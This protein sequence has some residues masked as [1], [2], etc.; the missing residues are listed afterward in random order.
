MQLAE[1]N[2]DGSFSTQAARRDV[3]AQAGKQL[4]GAGFRNLGAEGLKPKHVQKLLEVWKSDGLGVATIKNRVAHL[5]WWSEKV[6]K[7]NVIPAS[8]DALGLGRRS[9]VT[10]VSKSASLPV[11]LLADI[12][13]ERLRVSLELQSAFGLRREECLKFQPVKALKGFVPGDAVAIHLAASW[14]KGGRARSVPIRTEQQRE[15]LN[16]A[17]VLAG[18]GSMI[19]IDR[20]YVGW[21]GVYEQQTRRV[22]LKKMHG[23]RHAYAQKLY[24]Q[25]TGWPPPACGGPRSKDLSVDQKSID[26]TARLMVSREL[27]H[28][29]ESITTVYLGR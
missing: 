7:Q 16:R 25:L 28:G 22:G 27:G 9:F 15:V 2:K 14:C 11:G 21:L 10:N 20:T 5:R 3:L 12:K 17:L 24:E 26:L 29:R 18:S 8:N 4:L 23:L 1:R 13:D 6:G 19:P